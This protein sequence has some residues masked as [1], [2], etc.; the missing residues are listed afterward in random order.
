MKSFDKLALEAKI[1][2]E[3][4]GNNE[5]GKKIKYMKN[6]SKIKIVNA[7]VINLGVSIL[8]GLTR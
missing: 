6:R 7:I 8:L 2:M 5:T 4:I 1:R 3:K